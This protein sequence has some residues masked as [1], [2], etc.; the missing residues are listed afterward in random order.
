MVAKAIVDAGQIW[1]SFFKGKGNTIY[2][3]TDYKLLGRN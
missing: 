3:I 2:Q 1:V